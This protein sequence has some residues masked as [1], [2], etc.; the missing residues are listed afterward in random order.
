LKESAR[1]VVD[2][3][4]APLGEVGEVVEVADTVVFGGG[5]GLETVAVKIPVMMSE[6]TVELLTI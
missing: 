1:R 6:I 3:E 5:V 2:E 4:N